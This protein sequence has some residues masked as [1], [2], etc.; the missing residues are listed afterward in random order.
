MKLQLSQLNLRPPIWLASMRLFM[1]VQLPSNPQTLQMSSLWCPFSNILL[2]FPVTNLTF[3]FTACMSRGSMD[4][5][6]T[7]TSSRASFGVSKDFLGIRVFF[8]PRILPEGSVQNLAGYL[9][10]SKL[11][12]CVSYLD[13]CFLTQTFYFYFL[14]LYLL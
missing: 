9:I 3:W 10:A 11:E 14:S 7:N 8:G 12:T 5:K 6:S 13:L 4:V 1:N 2:L